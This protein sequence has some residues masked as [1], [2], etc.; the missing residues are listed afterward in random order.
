MFVSGFTFIRNA[1]KY[2]YPIREAILSI[3]PL[4]DEIVVA[5]GRS[6]DET[7]EL[8]KSIPTDKIRIVETEWDERLR[9]G[10]RVLADETNKA[11]AAISPEADWAV[12]I[13]GDEVM[14]EAG[15]ADVRRQME[16]WKDDSRVEGLVFNYRHFYGSYDYIGDSHRWYRREVRV[17]R[18]RKDIYSFRDAQGF[19]TDNR[20]LRVKPVAAHIHHYGWVKH[21]A[22]QQAKQ[23]SFNKLWHDDAWMDQNVAKV[24]EFDYSQVDSLS[25]FEGIHP[26]VMQERIRLMNWEFSFDPTQQKLSLKHRIKKGVEKATGWNPGEYR[27]FKV[28]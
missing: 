21:P 11:F 9:E 16:A 1:V 14:H 23:Q 6:E 15:H 17:I 3:A 22:A 19:Q 12:Y 28:I 7:L 2:D 10:G 20:P 5:V 26:Q 18:N 4:C 27:N 25:R 13:Q 24:D 8:V